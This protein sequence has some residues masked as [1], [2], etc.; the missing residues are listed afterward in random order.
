MFRSIFDHLQLQV[1]HDEFE[2]H[3][4]LQCHG[5][6]VI[7]LPLELA[8]TKSGT[9]TWDVGRAEVETRRCRDAGT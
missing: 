2:F 9:G 4:K 7:T 6:Y 1:A 5:A 3:L 8:V